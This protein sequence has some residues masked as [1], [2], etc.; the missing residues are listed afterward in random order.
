AF[1]NFNHR[2]AL[3]RGHVDLAAQRRARDGDRHDAVQVVAVARED[4]VLFQA[5]L[6]VQVARRPAVRAGLAVARAADAHAVVDAGGDLDFERLL[7]FHA[8]LA[9]ARGA[10]LGN[11]LARAAAMR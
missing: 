11:D 5:D 6:D 1:R 3:Q 7:L 4:L 10:G 9:V 2:I 8:A